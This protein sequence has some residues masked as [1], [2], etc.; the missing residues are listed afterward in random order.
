MAPQPE[1]MPLIRTKLHRP[2][3]PFDVVG[4]DRLFRLMDRAV[5]VP[6]TLVSAPAGYG[7]S[8]LAAHWADRC[9]HPVVWLSLDSDESDLRLFLQY[10]VAAVHTVVPGACRTTEDLLSAPELPPP[11]VLAGHLLN[12]L[13]AMDGPLVIVLDDYHR[14]QISSP[15]HDL[16]GRLL[17]HPPSSVRLVLVTRRDPP[18][19]FMS[20]LAG[21]QVTEVRLEDLR[22]TG[23]ETAEFL[24]A[25]AELVV[26]DNVL[27]NLEKQ[28]EGWAA[29]LRLVMLALR[30]AVDPEALLGGLGGGLPQTRAY[31][32]R[33]ALSGLSPEDR[34]WLL[35]SSILDRFCPPLLEAVCC[36]DGASA[37][38]ELTGRKF[39]D[40]IQRNNLFTIALDTEGE[41]FR[42]HH[43][44]QD[45]LQRQLRETSSSEEVAS[46][47]LR[48]GEW[49]E[50]EGLIDEALKHT[51]AADELE[52]AAQLVERHRIDALNA[53]QWYVLEKWLSRLPDSIV[54]QHAELL[55]AR[56]WILLRQLRFETMLPIVD[57]IDALLDGEGARQSRH[58]EVALF[59]GFVLFFQGH[60]AKSVEVLKEATERI[61]DSYHEPWC[62]A[63]T[64]FALANQMEGR[65]EQALCRIAKFLNRLEGTEDLR[66][67]RLL[68]VPVFIQLISADL[69]Q[70]RASNRL[71]REIT[72]G[73]SH[74]HVEA[75]S[76]YLEGLILLYRH[77]PDAAVETLTRSAK[78]RFI[79]HKKAAVDSLAGLAMAHQSLG[80]EDEVEA[81]LQQLRE[82]AVSLNDPGLS[83]MA[84]SAEARLAIYQQR[85]EMAIRWLESAV[86]P[87]PEV[88][89]FWFEIPSVTWCRALIA[90][91]SATRLGEAEDR[92]RE[93]SAMNEAHHNN[94]HLIEVLTLLATA[95]EKQKKAEEA[96]EYLE[97]AVTLAR[98]GG[99]IFPFIEA[100][101]TMAGMLE[102]LLESD[103]ADF[104]RRVLSAFSKRPVAAPATAAPAPEI[105]PQ[106]AAGSAAPDSLTNREL[107]VLELLAERLQNKEIASRLCV[108]THTVNYHLKSVYAKLGVGNRRQAVSR[109]FEMGILKPAESPGQE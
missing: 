38:P 59:R 39:L 36:P 50:A 79:H 101:P 76:V 65:K 61:P 26:S 82:F 108:S 75:W 42:Y 28:V 60:G 102:R 70:A 105:A 77:E 52:L 96:L 5:E 104:I 71:F 34:D 44:F 33:E 73:G 12:D 53:D 90:E 81:T 95:C 87:P 89:L 55:I 21:N 98:P 51:L 57:R 48:V 63:E 22:F 17:E 3:V 7:K 20:L 64:I 13:E 47:H 86:P 78:Q 99:F 91:D 45:L 92:L 97:R 40:L 10:L 68:A 103:E 94:C 16:M 30:H 93:L 74:A 15:V 14:I 72:S 6:L 66:M 29:G 25:T 109:A 4:R 41:W 43:L 23:R 85:P 54:Q 1:S 88:A 2:S 18:L 8:V 100:G 62:E 27:A 67:K 46:L 106:L 56:A 107:D 24:S 69:G 19:P 83:A 32:L 37:H 11:L 84:E 80:R 58:G 35:R 49:F 9:E 31:L